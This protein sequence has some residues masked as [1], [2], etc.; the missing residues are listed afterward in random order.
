MTFDFPLSQ[1]DA[2][3]LE[4]LQAD[5]VREGRQLEYKE[6]LPGETPE[7]KREFLA[8]VSSFANA[9]GGDLI[10]GVRERR[11]AD[12][13]P[14]GEIE[15][16]VGVDLLNLDAERL[17]LENLIRDGIAPRMPPVAFHAINR[18]PEKPCLL[19]RRV[20]RSWAGLHMVTFRNLSR[21]FSRAWGGKYQLDVQEIRAGFV[22]AETAHE[23]LRLFRTERVSRVLAL[24]APIP[25]GDGPKL[26]L[27]AL[28]IGLSSDVWIRFLLKIRE[29]DAPV[30]FA[31]QPIG[32][33]PD[34]WRFNVDGFV[35]H[36]L[37][38]ELARQSYTQLFRD[39]GLEVVSG[40]VLFK[41]ERYHGFFAWGM[42]EAIIGRFAK[43]QEFW[44]QVG[45]LA[46]LSVGLTLT[47]VKGWKVLSN[48]YGFPPDN[49][50]F[51]RDVVFSP[52]VVVSDLNAAADVVLRPLFDFVWNGGGWAQSPNYPDGRWVKPRF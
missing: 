16:I 38:S 4:M 7:D 36:T 11:D 40:R 23:R 43:F 37:G 18:G 27:H 25:L 33:T 1:V 30:A 12:K 51:D 10:F 48:P 47:G 34:T 3:R 31:L 39:G 44:T 15:A 6:V 21:F 17:R 2:T 14:T 46:P 35:V 45:V 9:A 32:G 29:N 13:V 8:D 49:D 50:G 26:I 52:E 28:P 22:A 24:E 42:E 41:V 5:G 19:I 20:P